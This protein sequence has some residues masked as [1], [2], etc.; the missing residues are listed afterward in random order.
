MESWCPALK[1]MSSGIVVFDSGVVVMTVVVTNKM[2]S[3]LDDSWMLGIIWDVCI[4]IIHK[5]EV[6]EVNAHRS[7]YILVYCRFTES[8]S[9]GVIK[10]AIAALSLND[11]FSL[12]FHFSQTARFT[13]FTSDL[14]LFTFCSTQFSQSILRSCEFNYSTVLVFSAV[15][16]TERR[17]RSSNCTKL[18]AENDSH[19]EMKSEMENFIMGL[20]EVRSKNSTE[21]CGRLQHVLS[22]AGGVLLGAMNN[23]WKLMEIFQAHRVEDFSRKISRSTNLVSVNT[24][25]RIL[26]IHQQHTACWVGTY[27]NCLPSQMSKVN[28]ENKS[29]NQTTLRLGAR[30][31]VVD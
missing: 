14:W 11:D 2:L 6:F 15:Y 9:C 5:R 29:W 31:W 18:I 13:I 8:M 17:W 25:R 1:I 30:D 10:T 12:R 22:S 3:M 21:S 19:E 23:N 24:R 16:V 26:C 27:A 7:C 20:Q 28:R 4:S